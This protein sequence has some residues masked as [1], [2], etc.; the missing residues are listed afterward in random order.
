MI[1]I[2]I[3][4]SSSNGKVNGQAFSS[5]VGEEDIS[6]LQTSICRVGGGVPGI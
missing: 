5:H 4:V 1:P 3:Q 2:D 6:I